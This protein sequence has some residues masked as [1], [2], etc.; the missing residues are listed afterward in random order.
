VETPAAMGRYNQC[1]LV[2]IIIN[3]ASYGNKTTMVVE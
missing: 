3:H 2:I 1:V